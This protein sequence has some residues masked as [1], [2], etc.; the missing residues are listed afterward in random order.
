MNHKRAIH[1]GNNRLF[2]VFLELKIKSQ[3]VNIKLNF[4]AYC[5]GNTP[6]YRKPRGVWRKSERKPHRGYNSMNIIKIAGIQGSHLHPAGRQTTP[7]RTP[8][9][10][11]AAGATHELSCHPGSDR[12]V[13]KC[14]GS[15]RHRVC[16]DHAVGEWRKA[17]GDDLHILDSDISRA[18]ALDHERFW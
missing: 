12:H 8:A 11:R 1:I 16:E 13:F 17:C 2:L 4:S 9:A 14:H 18:I 6:P 5:P 3:H 7:C 10:T 15:R